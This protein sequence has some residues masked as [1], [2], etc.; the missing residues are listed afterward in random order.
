MKYA[1]LSLS[2]SPAL[3][4]VVG[5]EREEDEKENLLTTSSAKSRPALRLVMDEI[6]LYVLS[7]VCTLWP[8]VDRWN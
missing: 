7:A 5:A 4:V 1:L 8:C 6:L 2:L 3:D